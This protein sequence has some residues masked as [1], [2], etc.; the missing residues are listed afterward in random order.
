MRFLVNIIV[1][2]QG[3]VRGFI[4]RKAFY[5]GMKDAGYKPVH[6]VLRKKFIGFKLGRI[7]KK[8]IDNM[9]QERHAF[10]ESIKQIDKNIQ[11]TEELLSGL[12]PNIS[13]MM[14]AKQEKK[15]QK[16]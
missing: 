7:S 14:Q 3:L 16:A 15:I 2:M 1:R 11:S 12:L 13:R 5:L 4:Q 8:Y 9:T 6:D 10:L